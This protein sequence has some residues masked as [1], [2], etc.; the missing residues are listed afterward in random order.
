MTYAGS[1]DDGVREEV[2]RIEHLDHSSLAG[3]I[4]AIPLPGMFQDRPGHVPQ[5]L[6]RRVARPPAQPPAHELPGRQRRPCR[7]RAVP[8]LLVGWSEADRHRASRPVRRD[9]RGR[10]RGLRSLSR[11]TAADSGCRSS[12]APDRFGRESFARPTRSS[13]S[14]SRLPCAPRAL[15]RRTAAGSRPT[16][17]SEDRRRPRS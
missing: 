3:Q 4:A 11:T 15:P 6:R 17:R 16:R 12:G 9:R 1:L 2:V 5:V 14:R 7:P 13:R 8:V 10:V